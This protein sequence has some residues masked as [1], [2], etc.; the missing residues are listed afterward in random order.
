LNLSCIRGPIQTGFTFPLTTTK[1]VG[2]ISTFRHEFFKFIFKFQ[3][4]D[5]MY[6]KMI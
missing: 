5:Q 6:R 1:C 2:E 3:I 4:L